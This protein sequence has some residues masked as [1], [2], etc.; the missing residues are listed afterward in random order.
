M[1]MTDTSGAP[2]PAAGI[3]L[4]DGVSLNL[5]KLIETRLIVQASTGGGK[6]YAIRRLLEQSHGK[7]QHIMIDAEGSLRTLPARALRIPPARQ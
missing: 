5:T 1:T 3:A 7:V 6:T 4:S 2:S